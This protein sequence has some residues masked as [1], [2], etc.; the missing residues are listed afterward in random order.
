MLTIV[1]VGRL[2][3]QDSGDAALALQGQLT[4]PVAV[5]RQEGQRVQ[6]AAVGSVN[7]LDT[8]LSQEKYKG[9]ELRYVFQTFR[10]SERRPGWVTQQTSMLAFQDAAPRADNSDYIGGMF[11]YAYALRR[12]WALGTQWSLEAGGQVEGGVGFLYSTRNSNNPAQARLYM[13]LGPSVAA[14]FAFPFRKKR[15]RVRYEAAA[16]LVGVMFSPNYGQSYYEIFTRGNYDHNAVPTTAICAPTLRQQL[17][18]DVPFRRFSL[19]V[20]YLGDYQQAAVNNL[21]YHAYS[22]LLLVGIVRPLHRR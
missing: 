7:L 21:K 4:D 18:V 10:P 14:S 16:P 11:T 19:R 20:G 9:T 13:N 5:N 1:S 15:L 3:A 22:H 12:E 6:A 2:A 8:Y 17:T